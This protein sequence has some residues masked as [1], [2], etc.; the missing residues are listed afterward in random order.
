MDVKPEKIIIIIISQSLRY[1]TLIV[2]GSIGDKI[3]L[4]DE[5]ELR[6]RKL[7]LPQRLGLQDS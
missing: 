2:I 7:I 6:E 5:K 3:G 4:Q 1:W